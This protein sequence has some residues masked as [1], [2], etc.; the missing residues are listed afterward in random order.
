[1]SADTTTIPGYTEEAKLEEERIGPTH[2][3]AEPIQRGREGMAG[4]GRKSAD[5]VVGDP[6]VSESSPT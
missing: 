2:R 6:G 3:G 5:G 4:K 1:M